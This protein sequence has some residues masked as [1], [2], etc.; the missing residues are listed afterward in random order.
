[1][2]CG[3]GACLACVIPG[4][5]TPFLVSCQEGPVLPPSRIDW[6]RCR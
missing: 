2:G 3:F 5:E 4:A 1:M 6:G